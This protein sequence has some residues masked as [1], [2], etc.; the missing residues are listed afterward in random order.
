MGLKFCISIYRRY[1]DVEIFKVAIRQSLNNQNS[2]ASKCSFLI[3]KGS[4]WII[5]VALKVNCVET[6]SAVSSNI[7][8]SNLESL[9]GHACR[10]EEWWW[11][12][13]RGRPVPFQC[14]ALDFE[15][16]LRPVFGPPN[17]RFGV[18]CFED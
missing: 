18:L 1:T 3:I 7:G 11:Q 15:P 4:K 17:A 6:M 9:C 10:S 2:S 14:S 13:I 16:D 8:S 5:L 12:K